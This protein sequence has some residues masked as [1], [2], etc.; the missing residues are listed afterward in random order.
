MPE[1]LMPAGNLEKLEYAVTYGA[2]AVYL[3]MVDLSLRS[4]KSGEIIDEFNIKSAVDTAHKLGAKAYMTANIFAFDEDIEILKRNLN[5]IR[6]AK[7]DAIIFSDFG[8]MNVLKKELPEIPLHVSTQTNILNTEAVK[9]W[10]DMG[11]TR[12]ILARELSLEQIAKIKK[13]VP[14]IEVEVFVHGAQCMSFSGRCLLSDYMTADERKANHGNCAQPCRWNYKLLEETR[15]G[16]YYDITEYDKGTTI[17][18]PKDLCLI[19]YIPQLIDAGVDSFKVEGRT[20]STY[21]AS[22]VAKTYR[23]A[24]DEYLKKGTFDKDFY[25]NELWKVR[26]RGYTTGF[27]LDKSQKGNYTYA[28]EPSDIG[29][30]FCVQILG[31]E[32]KGYKALIKNNVDTSETYE[33]VSPKDQFSTKLVKIFDEFG[34]EEDKATTNDIVYLTFEQEPIE[35]S[36]ALLRK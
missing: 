8:I 10:Q 18:S 36:H 5:L 25:K 23:M 20:K 15:P 13:N 19:E 28:K 27:F 2:D 6:E 32:E 35:Y 31:K 30:T 16:E 24:I 33:F 12:V 9:F 11:A 17:L 29:N 26:N 22:C 21:Y 7:P 34:N 1:L 14:D 4:M 3:G